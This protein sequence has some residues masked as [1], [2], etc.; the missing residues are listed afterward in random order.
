MIKILFLFFVILSILVKIT[1]FE[2]FWPKK[3]W[4]CPFFRPINRVLTDP[5]EVV[6]VFVFLRHYTNCLFS[7]YLFF[8]ALNSQNKLIIS[9]QT[10][11]RVNRKGGVVKL[12]SPRRAGKGRGKGK[13]V[14]FEI[15]NPKFQFIR[16]KWIFDSKNK[17]G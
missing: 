14:N 2:Y 11:R 15:K 5:I 17:N 13:K 10:P 6:F 1:F 16:K 7:I 12:A 9:Q 4:F 3:D 8:F